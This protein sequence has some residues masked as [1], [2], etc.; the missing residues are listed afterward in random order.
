[1]PELLSPAG[2]YEKMQSALRFGA[3]AVYLAGLDFGMRSAAANFSLEE[4]RRAVKEVHAAGKKLYLTVNTMP[5]DDEYERLAKFLCDVSDFGIDAFIVADIGVIGLVQ[6]HVPGAVIHL[7]TQ[8]NTVSAASC[9]AWHALGV[10]RIVLARELTLEEIKYI[11]AHTPKSLELEVFIHGSMCI[12]MSGR[13][14]ISNYLVGRDAN[15][16]SC[17]QPCR[18]DYDFIIRQKNDE[19]GISENQHGS[20]IMASKDMCMIEHIPE[21]ME[22]GIDSFKIEGRMKSAYYT[23][24]VTNTYRMA[25]QQYEKDRENFRYDERWLAELSSVT[26]REYCTGYFFDQPMKN[27]QTVSNN[28]YLKEKAYL[29]IAEGYDPQSGMACFVQRNK[30]ESFSRAEL[31]QPGCCGKPIEVGQLYDGEGAPIDSVPH[32]YMRFMLKTD[33]PIHPGDILRG[34]SE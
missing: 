30:F 3:D 5:H 6:E 33:I 2:N 29:A 31:L 28:G 25:M 13:C 1:M 15:R 8:A 19:L 18:W 12:S 22:S 27:A 26:H 23:A 7:S 10:S 17:A 24:V 11:R 14:L 4:L 16:G 20:F 34:C 9:R 32:P 21:L